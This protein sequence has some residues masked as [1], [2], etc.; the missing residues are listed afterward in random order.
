MNSLAIYFGN[1]D[2]NLVESS[3]KKILKNIRLPHPSI[4]ST[5]LE[6]KVPIDIKIIALLKDALRTHRINADQAAVCISGQD[7]V[8]RT[9]EIPLIPQNEL[10]GV[11][12][13]EIK[14]YIPFKL[15][16]LVYDFQTLL[17]KSNK[18][19]LVLFVGIKKELLSS[20]I[21]IFKQLNLRIG[22]LEYS[23]FSLLRLLKLSGINDS[24]VKACLCFDLNN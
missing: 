2:I 17:N 19:S 3:G 9:F 22:V 13:F 16:E 20:Y 14:K 11:V 1:K 7:L 6:E 4:D 21:S 23:A 12:S 10:K 5:E 24:G 15:E 18:T 8:I